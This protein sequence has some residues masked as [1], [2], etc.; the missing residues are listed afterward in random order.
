MLNRGIGSVLALICA[1]V[2][3]TQEAT[4]GEGPQLEVRQLTHGPK[5]HFFGYIG[6][7]GN[8]PWSGDGR[9]IVALRTDWKDE[10]PGVDDSAE[11]VLIDT[12]QGDKVVAV[13]RSR[14]WNPQQGTMLYWNPKE[15]D[16]QLFFNDRDP[17][18]GKVFCVLYDVRERRRIREFK[19]E[20]TPVGNGGV[21]Q[22]GGYFFG[23][24]Y[25]RMA[26]LR[27]V[28]GYAGA[29]D[30]TKGVAHPEDDGIFRIDVE[31]GE[32]RLIA[33][34]QAIAGEVQRKLGIEK[35][36][37]L[38]IN[39]TLA[40]RENDRVFFFARG[41]WDGN[42]GRKVNVGFVMRPDGTGL[43]PL[44]QHIGGHPEWAEGNRMIGRH[45]DRQIIFDVD[46]DEIVGQLGDPTIFPNPEGDIAL[47]PDAKWFV[48]GW[49]D[50]KKEAMFYSILRRGDGMHLRTK[51]FNIGKYQ[52]GDL[53]QDPSPCWNRSGDQILVPRVEK[54]GKSRQLFIIS[55][56]K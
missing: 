51:G 44:K 50:R 54:D 45:K 9:Y 40:N 7:A 21:A 25:A 43:K 24:N 10:L 48:N 29:W 22:K 49:K 4:C 14:A 33:S 53:R 32:Q 1:V 39:H 41:G 18:T 42:S 12:I 26:R 3:S 16:T 8:V 11:V 30:W 36:P 46:K 27:A 56:K 23:I 52:S 15:P 2:C 6:H 37:H 35:V 34:F 31:T 17:K 13:D 55:I 47:S 28:T 38:F 20:K 19:F 5:T